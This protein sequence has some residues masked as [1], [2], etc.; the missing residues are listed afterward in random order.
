M[1]PFLAKADEMLAKEVTVSDED[2]YGFEKSETRRT[3]LQLQEPQGG[4]VTPR[5]PWWRRLGKSILSVMT[6]P[7]WT[8]LA[9]L[10][11]A[12]ITPLQVNKTS[13]FHYDTHH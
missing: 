7:T 1:V 9:S 12:A 11:V 6:P 10:I 2:L 3:G 13:T 4:E 5:L 8:A